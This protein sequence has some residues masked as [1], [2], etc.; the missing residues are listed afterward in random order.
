VLTRQ[1]LHLICACFA[2]SAQ[3]AR[4]SGTDDQLPSLEAVV[5]AC[6]GSRH[7]LHS[8]IEPSAHLLPSIQIALLRFV[9]FRSTSVKFAPSKFASNSI[10]PDRSA[11]VR[12]APARFA[13]VRFTTLRSALPISQPAQSTF[14]PAGSLHA[15]SAAE[16]VDRHSAMVVHMRAS[17]CLAFGIISRTFQKRGRTHIACAGAFFFSIPGLVR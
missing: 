7:Y 11:P 2:G 4:E 1:R 6:L 5:W 13:P 8:P 15:P 14:G 16:V 12:S 9:P 10:A 3:F 17:F